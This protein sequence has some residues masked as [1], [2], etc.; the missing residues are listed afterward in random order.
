M[1]VLSRQIARQKRGGGARASPPAL[2]IC[3]RYCHEIADERV[4]LLPVLPNGDRNRA[5]GHCA[6]CGSREFTAGEMSET[7]ERRFLEG[8]ERP[9]P[10]ALGDQVFGP[11]PFIRNRFHF[12]GGLRPEGTGGAQV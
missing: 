7:Y 5:Q 4:L 9:I 11:D 6:N 1:S 2:V 8:K 10:V 3:C 12:L